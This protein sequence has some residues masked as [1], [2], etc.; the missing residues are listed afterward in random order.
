MLHICDG[1]IL[2]ISRLNAGASDTV[3][4]SSNPSVTQS[5]LPA[6]EFGQVFSSLLFPP[7]TLTVC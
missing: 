1:W 7:F 4:H 3:S 6:G 5:P 2:S